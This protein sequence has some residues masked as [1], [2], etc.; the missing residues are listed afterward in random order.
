MKLFESGELILSEFGSRV[1]DVFAQY[2]SV[3]H[4]VGVDNGTNAP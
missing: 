3:R 2:C 4:G 1:E